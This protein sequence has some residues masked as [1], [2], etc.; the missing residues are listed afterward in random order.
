VTRLATIGCGEHATGSH[1]PSLALYAARHPGTAP[2]NERD[3]V[4]MFIEH[5]YGRGAGRC[6]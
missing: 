5:R 3:Y 4:A 2:M 1:G 6:C